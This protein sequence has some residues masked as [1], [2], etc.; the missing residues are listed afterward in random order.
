[1]SKLENCLLKVALN[2]QTSMV[3]LDGE[4]GSEEHPFVWQFELSHSED[5][6]VCRG[7]RETLFEAQQQCHK[8]ALDYLPQQLPKIV[9]F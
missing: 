5:G 1:M 2:S 8:A 6:F 7:V 3:G 4:L 9:N